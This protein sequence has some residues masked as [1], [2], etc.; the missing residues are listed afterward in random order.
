MDELT[1]IS[2]EGRQLALDRFRLLQ[3]HLEG[4][5]PLRAV[6]QKA[7]IPYRT[8]QRWVTQYRQFGLAALNRKRRRDCGERRAVSPRLCEAIEGLAL[9][10]PPL[11]IT[12]LY[13]QLQCWAR[14]RG[15]T[16]PSYSV[17]Y[18]LSAACPLT[19]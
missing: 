15:E 4:N 12:L 9:Q 19:C 13:R 14:E 18:A 17:V 10:K 7:G 2:E 8:A 5:Q 6:A 16:V 1:S 3:P 11:P